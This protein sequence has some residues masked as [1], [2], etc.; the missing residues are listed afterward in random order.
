[1]TAQDFFYWLQGFIELSTAAAFKFMIGPDVARCILAHVDLIPED[2]RGAGVIEVRTLVRL[3]SK[4]TSEDIARD[5]TREIAEAVASVFKHVIDPKAGD[6][7][8]QARLN[9]IH[10]QNP[11]LCPRPYTGSPVIRC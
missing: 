7:D 2:E 4:A 1:M 3:A 6:A 8:E 5:L 9:A 10:E 11:H